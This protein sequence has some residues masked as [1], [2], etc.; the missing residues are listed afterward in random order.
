MIPRCFR[1]PFD[2]ASRDKDAF[3]RHTPQTFVRQHVKALRTVCR[4]AAYSFAGSF[5]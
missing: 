5:S 3:S 2:V 4:V 1:I